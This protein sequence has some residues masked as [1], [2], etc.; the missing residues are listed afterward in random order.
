M[1]PVTAVTAVI[2]T[3]TAVTTVTNVTLTTGLGQNAYVEH[4]ATVTTLE[5]KRCDSLVRHSNWDPPIALTVPL[6]LD[7]LTH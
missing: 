2:E 4:S 5:I 3:M 6:L 1:L 7:S